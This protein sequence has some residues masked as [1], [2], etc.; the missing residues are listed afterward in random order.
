MV[1]RISLMLKL[2]APS[3]VT[4]PG[5]VWV[6]Q[7]IPVVVWSVIC[8]TPRNSEINKIWALFEVFFFQIKKY[9]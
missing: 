3:Q 5:S 7:T 9:L 1:Q 6:I 2:N 8:L 4:S